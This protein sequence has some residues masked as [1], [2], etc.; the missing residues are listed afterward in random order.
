MNRV[1]PLKGIANSLR[2]IP[3]REATP[4]RVHF[5]CNGALFKVEFWNF[6]K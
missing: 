3:Q 4:L 2:G 5:H 1:V 6:E